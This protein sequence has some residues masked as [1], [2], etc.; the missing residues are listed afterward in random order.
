[1][2]ACG[3]RN[4]LVARR[5]IDDLIDICG[6]RSPLKYLKI[7][8]KQQI[9]NHRWFIAR[10]RDEIRT[11]TNLISQL[12]ALITELEASGDY[13]EVFDLVKELQD[14]KRDEQD[15][16]A[17]FNRL[18][19]VVEEKI[20]GKEIDLEI[21]EAEGNDGYADSW[22]YDY[23]FIIH[24]FA[25]NGIMFGY[26]ALSFE[27]EAPLCLSVVA[28]GCAIGIMETQAIDDQ[29]PLVNYDNDNENDDVVYQSEEYFD[30]VLEDDENNHLNG[31]VVKRGITRLYKF[32][33]EYGKPDGIKLIVTF[34]ALNRIPGKHRALFSSFLGYMV[35]EHIGLKILSWK[36]V[37]SEAR[38][39]FDVDLTV[40]KLVMNHLGQLLRNFRK[41]LRQ[42]YI[43]PNQNTLSKLNEVPAKYS[44][45]L[46]AEE[47]VNFV[48]YTATE[49]YK[50]RKKE[51]MQRGVGSGVT[52]KRILISRGRQASY[53]KVSPMDINPINS[54]ADEEGGPTVVGCEI[55]A[56]I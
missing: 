8:I 9:T 6:E 46:Q 5:V 49:E 50:V 27:C 33:R 39:Y 19:V 51:V 23:G 34:D 47:W 48:K 12:N 55:D 31:N 13:E 32:R 43:L 26:E 16:V 45:I 56:S 1:M 22:V 52:Y 44:E 14:D 53:E 15:K 36:K 29:D 10:M 2:A 7:F 11:S 54:S 42:T 37:D 25:V 24:Y 38:R 3:G 28:I 30:E 4:N 18:I 41:K 35:R 40:K 20:H 21:L 17:D